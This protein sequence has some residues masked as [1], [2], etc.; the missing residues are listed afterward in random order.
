MSILPDYRNM[1]LKKYLTIEEITEKMS[2]IEPE[3]D[4]LMTPEEMLE[5]ANQM[6]QGTYK[7]TINLMMSWEDTIKAL[8]DEAY[9]ILENQ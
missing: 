8:R 4:Y 5:M 9:E 1:P 6:E 7:G 3:P 2:K